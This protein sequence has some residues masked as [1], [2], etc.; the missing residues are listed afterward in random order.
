M[1]NSKVTQGLGPQGK[2]QVLEKNLS[3]TKKKS[4]TVM[5]KKVGAPDQVKEFP[6]KGELEESGPSAE[7]KNRTLKGGNRGSPFQTEGWGTPKKQKLKTCPKS[8]ERTLVVGRDISKK[9]PK[10]QKSPES[11]SGKKHSKQNPE[12]WDDNIK[13]RKHRQKLLIVQ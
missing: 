9:C 3:D 13:R 7:N 8:Q 4:T 10:Q 12:P 5:L 2:S 6:G 1:G 11:Y